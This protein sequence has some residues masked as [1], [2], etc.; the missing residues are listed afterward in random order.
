MA[1][2]AL[3]YLL[4][5]PL[6]CF[7]CGSDS[8][9]EGDLEAI[10]SLIITEPASF[11]T[12]DG[13]V[14]GGSYYASNEQPGRRPAVVLVHMRNRDHTQWAPFLPDL[15]VAGHRVLAYDV[16]GHGL[17]RYQRGAYVPISRFEPQQLEQMPLDVGAAVSWLKE[18]QDVDPGRIAVVGADLGANIAY[19]GSGVFPGVKATVAISIMGRQGD[20]F[21]VGQGVPDFQPHTVLYLAS[22]GDGYT[23]TFSEALATN[24]ISP[25]RVVGYQGSANGVFLLNLQEAREEIFSWLLENL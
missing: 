13:F 4:L 18:R 7:G 24:T 11:T 1:F 3:A 5:P 16:R 10:P 20:A 22:F 8:P 23:Y 21:L 15:V 14:I 25:T 19:V 17:S 12:T 9:T 2:R 6:L